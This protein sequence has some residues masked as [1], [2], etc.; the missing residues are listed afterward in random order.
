M[1]IEAKEILGYLGIPEADVTDIEK[2]KEKFNPAFIKKD[3]EIIRGDDALVGQLFGAKSKAT[4]I[5]ISRVLKKHGIKVEDKDFDGPLEKVSEKVIDSAISELA[6][7]ISELE[8]GAGKGNDEK[9]A[10]L[11]KQYDTLKKEKE[12]IETKYNTVT[13]EYETFKTTSAKQFEDYKINSAVDKVLGSFKWANG[14][15][16]LVKEGFRSRIEKK[17]KPAFDDKGTLIAL[18]DKGEKIPNAKTAG[19][20]KT[21]EEAIIEDGVEAKIYAIADNKRAAPPRNQPTPPKNPTDDAALKAD[22]R[23]T[24]NKTVRPTAQA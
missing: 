19:T 9:L 12:G 1:A 24:I 13:G 20:F 21:Y 18:N 7:K 8:A 5:A 3:L 17:Y 16:D 11:Q 22:P 15:N 10:A 23:R 2:F 14:V 6:S 4:T